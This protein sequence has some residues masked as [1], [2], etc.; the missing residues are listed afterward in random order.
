M[1]SYWLPLKEVTIGCIEWGQS[2]PIA[3]DLCSRSAPLRGIQDVLQLSSNG[4]WSNNWQKCGLFCLGNA[5]WQFLFYTT[6]HHITLLPGLTVCNVPQHKITLFWLLLTWWWYQ[7]S[8][9]HN[10]Q[11]IL[12]SFSNSRF[13]YMH[14]YIFKDP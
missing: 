12:L 4:T 8:R 2:N 9:L 3:L 14:M 1:A 10:H 13:Y 6:R 7:P 11:S 5:E